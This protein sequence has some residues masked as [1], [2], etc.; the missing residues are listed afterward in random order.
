MN[1]VIG[2]TGLLLDTDLTGEQREYASTVRTSA[3]NLLTIVND[4]LDFSKIE[5]GK[6]DLEMVD[7]RLQT[8][9]ED[10]LALFADQAR[11]RGLELASFVEPG[12]LSVL[13]GDPGRLAQVLINLLGNAVKFTERGEVVV[14]T[15]L[16]KGD[17]KGV[18][19]RFSVGDTG[20]GL[21]EEQRSRLFQAFTQADPSTTRRYGGTGLGLAISK[22]LVELMGGEIWVESE[23]GVGSIFYFTARFER[24]TPD[25][26]SSASPLQVLDGRRVLVV[27][28]NASNR[29]VLA[30]QLSSW[31][32]DAATAESAAGGFEALREAAHGGKPYELALIDLRMPG[33]D[34]T[35]MARVIKDDPALSSTGLILLASDETSGKADGIDPHGFSVVL[36]KPL[37]RS[38]LYD[39]IIQTLGLAE[40]EE[41]GPDRASARRET[42]GVGSRPRVL[43]AQDNA[44]N[45]KVA[46]RMLESMDYRADVVANGLEAVEAVSRVPYAVVLMDVQM[47]E[48]DGHAATAEIRRREQQTNTHVPIIA[49]TADAM[50]GDREKA[51]DAGMDDYLAKP[52]RRDD[53]QKILARWIPQAKPDNGQAGSPTPDVDAPLDREVLDGLRK[54]GDENLLS[55]LV[56][57]FLEDVPGRLTALRGAVGSGDANAVER[58]AHALKGSCGN[59]GAMRMSAIAS[60]LQDAGVSGDLSSAPALLERLEEEYGRVRQTLA[61]E[62]APDAG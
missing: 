58:N 53:L 52:G 50:E 6:L 51:L 25:E 9:V 3:E 56:G 8:T 17:E 44:V 32:L 54:L 24:G 29:E 7:F 61:A 43:V 40:G 35:E 38:R 12:P 46:T 42:R 49:I 36:T 39:A 19:L 1:G 26:T 28:D 5:A 48:M 59:M 23:P 34:G 4:I 57:L 62:V 37:R 60:E 14:R 47:P 30:H 41:P 16:V 11:A 27:E 13:R 55:E 15:D 31:G 18:L 10:T 20:I 33:M 45:Q 22:Q 21:T 2:M